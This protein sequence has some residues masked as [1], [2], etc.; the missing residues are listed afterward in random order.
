MVAKENELRRVSRVPSTWTYLYSSRYTA[1]EHDHFSPNQNRY[2]GVDSGPPLEREREGRRSQ[3]QVYGRSQSVDVFEPSLRREKG[4]FTPFANMCA[5]L[6]RLCLSPMCNLLLRPVAFNRR[7]LLSSSQT[8]LPPRKV[9]KLQS[10]APRSRL[11]R[12]VPTRRLPPSTRTTTRSL[13]RT[14]TP[15]CP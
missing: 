14:M 7:P 15:R 11:L 9:P 10:R 13:T 8:R 4:F 5:N 2:T 6:P 1:R 12:I 3:Y